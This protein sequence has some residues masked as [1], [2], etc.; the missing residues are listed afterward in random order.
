MDGLHVERVA[1]DERDALPPA[2]VR[3]PVPGEH[4]LDGDDE[5]VSVGLHSLNEGLRTASH[6]L[7]QQNL[8]FPVKDAQVHGLGMQIDPAVVGVSLGVESHGSSP[9]MVDGDAPTS[10]LRAE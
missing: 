1:E 3:Q 5:I 10:L 6:I 7:V 4:A 8:T 9:E 2:E